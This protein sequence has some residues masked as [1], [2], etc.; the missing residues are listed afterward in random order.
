[1]QI[2]KFFKEFLILDRDG[3]LVWPF[4]IL[5]YVHISVLYFTLR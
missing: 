5:F 1:M 4:Y 2:Q 3:Q